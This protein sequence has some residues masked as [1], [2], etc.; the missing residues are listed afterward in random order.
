VNNLTTFSL[1]TPKVNK[2]VLLSLIFFCFFSAKADDVAFFY[3]LEADFS[4]LQ[5]EGALARQPVK[6][7]Q[8]AIQVVSLGKHKVYA[9]K[10]GSGAVETATSAQA[11]LA[12]FRCD[13]AFSIGP[14]GGLADSATPGSWHWVKQATAYQRGSWTSAGF[15]LNKASV[16]GFEEPA[17][18]ARPELFRGAGPIT[19]A[20]GEIFVN[21][22]SYREQ[23]RE[24]SGAEAV[25]MNLFGLATVCADHRV[26]LTNWRVVSDKADDNAGEDFR[27]FTENYKGEG[28]KALAELIKNLPP[29]PNSPQSYPELEKLLNNPSASAS[30]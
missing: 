20:S 17:Q 5:K 27:K 15:Q 25:D 3:A 6:V 7:G 8:R 29:N 28:G 1:V 4:A 12:R 14:V 18:P 26:T 21:S 30:P 11:L 24:T 13:R 10:M 9:V 22:S 23:L 19:V 16:V 2:Y